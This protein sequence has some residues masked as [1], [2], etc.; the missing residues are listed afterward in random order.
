LLGK[1]AWNS[2]AAMYGAVGFLVIASLWNA[3]PRDTARN[4]VAISPN[5]MKATLSS[6]KGAFKTTS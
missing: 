4:E 1:F 6:N 5:P 2:Y 3:W